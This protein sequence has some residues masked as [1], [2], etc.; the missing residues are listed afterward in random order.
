MMSEQIETQK[1][2]ASS[3]S[4]QN[5]SQLPS[6]PQQTNQQQQQLQQLQMLSSSTHQL[7]LPIPPH[8][9]AH[10]GGAA[11]LTPE[12][13]ATHN[14]IERARRESLND[15]FH[16]LAMSIPS[17]R[18]IR[19][20]SKSLIVQKSLEHIVE[21]HRR[22]ETMETALTRLQ[23]RVAELEE[24][25]RQARDG[26]FA[27]LGQT[28]TGSPQPISPVGTTVGQH[29]LPQMQQF[30]IPQNLSQQLV[31][32]GVSSV[33]G[34]YMAPMPQLQGNAVDQMAPFALTLQNPA[35]L[36]L[37][38][39]AATYT[40]YPTLDATTT[41][42][43]FA[44]FNLPHNYASVSSPDSNYSDSV[45][46]DDEPQTASHTVPLDFASFTTATGS[47][48]FFPSYV[49]FRPTTTGPNGTVLTP[50]PS[51]QSHPQLLLQGLS[52]PKA[53]GS[54]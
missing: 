11:R 37:G 52:V 25:S 22:S 30:V 47:T 48:N 29:T 12:K 39:T 32:Q 31:Q 38:N 41:G 45:H 49:P 50:S 54:C 5:Y 4:F 44:P 21:L 43:S 35:G 1:H 16:K 34:P 23:R 24:G 13:R 9:T 27:A 19:K 10:S 42:T 17:L 7:Q 53:T 20:P 36:A 33:P 51:P 46:S 40:T 14:A 28:G 26:V 6:A 2:I 15:R 18:Q 8:L 3:V